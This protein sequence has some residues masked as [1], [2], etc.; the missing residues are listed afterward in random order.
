MPVYFRTSVVD[1]ADLIWTHS[2][3]GVLCMTLMLA[4]RVTDGHRTLAHSP[5]N[6]ACGGLSTFL[7]VQTR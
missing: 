5:A 7:D 3:A 1:Y 2:M 6:L 4:S